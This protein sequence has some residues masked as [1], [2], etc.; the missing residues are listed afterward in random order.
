MLGVPVMRSSICSG[1]C[2]L[3]HCEYPTAQAHFFRK[4]T[5]RK[6]FRSRPLFQED[7][8]RQAAKGGVAISSWYNLNMPSI[9]C[10]YILPNKTN[11]VL[12]TGVTNNLP[13]RVYEHRQKLVKRYNV[14]KLV[15]YETFDNPNNAITR[16]KQIKAGSRKKKIALIDAFNPGWC[17]LYRSIL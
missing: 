3:R 4:K 12:Y 13:R 6:F 17:D 5:G 15:Y 10:V 14:S 7:S 1:R 16:E 8:L 2:P 11:R 9:Y